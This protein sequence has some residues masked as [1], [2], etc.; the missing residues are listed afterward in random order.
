MPFLTLLRVFFGPKSV[1]SIPIVSFAYCETVQ[2]YELKKYTLIQ[3]PAPNQNMGR[4][5][6]LSVG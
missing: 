6:I 1:S 2:D 5:L 3:V 4:L